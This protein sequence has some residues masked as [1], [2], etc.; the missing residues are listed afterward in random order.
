MMRAW[1]IAIDE[2]YRGQ[3]IFREIWDLQTKN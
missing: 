3:G 1:K 2:M